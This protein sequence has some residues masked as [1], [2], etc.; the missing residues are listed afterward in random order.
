[1]LEDALAGY[2]RRERLIRVGIAL[3]AGILIIALYWAGTFLG[4]ILLAVII[5]LFFR[6][7]FFTTSAHTVLETEKPPTTVEAEFTGSQSPV[8]AVQWGLATEIIQVESGKTRYEFSPRFRRG[9]TQMLVTTSSKQ[10]TDTGGD[11]TLTVTTGDTGWATIDVIWEASPTGTR[12][13][14]DITSERKFSL[15]YASQGISAHL[16]YASLLAAQGYQVDNRSV[17]IGF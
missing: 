3:L 4:A 9:R 17:D 11:C 2:V 14:V 15:A 16:Q 10:A 8:L 7:Q 6:I 12:V 13:A 1:M 5:A